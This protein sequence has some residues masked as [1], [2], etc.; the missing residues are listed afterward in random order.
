MIPI[1]GTRDSTG[2]FRART[3]LHLFYLFLA[4]YPLIQSIL[5]T[6]SSN[7]YKK[8]V[9]FYKHD[10]YHV[11]PRTDLCH[12]LSF[13]SPLIL[14]WKLKNPHHEKGTAI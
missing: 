10:F 5:S 3:E 1:F 13:S 7:W 8:M 11:M 12:D 2:N 14:G 9:I 6:V 4:T